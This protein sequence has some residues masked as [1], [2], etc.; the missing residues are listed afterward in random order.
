MSLII[1]NKFM[2]LLNVA[3]VGLGRA[4][5]I[6]AKNILKNKKLKL[7]YICDKNIEQAKQFMLDH[8]SNCDIQNIKFINYIELCLEDNELNIVV[9]TTPTKYHY[10]GTKAALE[11]GKHV[12]CEKPLSHSTSEIDELYTIAEKK[13]LVLLCAYNRRFDPQI[14]KIKTDVENKQL[15][16]LSL[17]NTI[18]RDYPYPTPA[19]IKQ[20]SGI[21]HDC[22]V[23]D[24]DYVNWIAGELPKTVYVVGNFVTSS[25]VNC[26]HHDNVVIILTYPSGCIANI[27]LSRISDNYDQRL[28]VFGTN[29]SLKIE[30]NYEQYTSNPISFPEKYA[31]SY[32]N[33]LNYL[34]KAIYNNVSVN[35]LLITKKTC[36]SCYDI[37]EA[38]E[39]SAKHKGP[40]DIVY[41]NNFR[42]YN[43]VQKA[44]KDN[45]RKARI[46][47]T[48]SYVKRMHT[49]YLQ[50][51]REMTLNEIFNRLK[52]FVDVSDPDISLP[53]YYHGVQTAEQMRADG[54]PEWFQFVGLIHDIGKIMFC[55]GCEEDGTSIKE[56]W[57]IV[58]DTF[59]VGCKL[60][61][62][63]G[64]VFPE[65][66]LLNKDAN[67]SNYNTTLGIYS[68]GCGLD[69]VLCSW[70]H[71]EYLYQVLRHNKISLPEE[72]YYIIRFH[73]LYSYHKFG[74]YSFFKNEKDV[75][76]FSWLKLFNKYDLYTKTENF[77]V[78]KK[79][80]EYYDNL[81][82]K[83]IP[84]NKLI[85]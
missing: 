23:H 25:D 26:G 79:I 77:K 8:Y 53:N 68:E 76:M 44:I 66:N 48:V 78:T 7:L 30:N 55:W 20:S 29:G 36:L 33:E 6:H 21:F 71:D 63:N 54:M 17:I 85:L 5:K 37:V 58:G 70:G 3:L 13:Q 11:S 39:Q 83:F 80:E 22:A 84:G 49:K 40:V 51:K 35:D 56:Q 12:F 43:A 73:S 82:K 57:G 62:K 4:G 45:Y 27:T 19:Y 74:E 41:T 28:Q 16:K 15:G 75:K 10:L 42:N 31:Q 24:I 69:N 32:I 46:N 72:A 9:I 14:A 2:N 38:C 50:F 67:N 47:Q 65:F 60:P 34:I 59:I 61:G 18:S 64:I 52:N 81:V 1:L